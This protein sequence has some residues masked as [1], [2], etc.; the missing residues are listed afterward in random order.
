MCP[1]PC[2][3]VLILFFSPMPWTI[4]SEIFPLWCRG[5]CYS[6]TTSFNWFFN[7][8]VSV[9]FLTL[10]RAVTKQGAF[11]IYASFGII[12]F[13]YFYFNLPETKGK[14]LEETAT[15]FGG[16]SIVSLTSKRQNSKAKNVKSYGSGNCD[17]FRSCE[18][19]SATGSNKGK[20]NKG[21]QS[22]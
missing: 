2:P 22:D 11:W 14:S 19:I 9:T 3:Q 1:C 15:L 17:L 16:P 12:G 20:Y 13:I 6:T 5:V 18:N 7:F 21:Y 10:T 4:N 8:L